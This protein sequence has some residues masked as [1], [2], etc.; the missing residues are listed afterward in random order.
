MFL[1]NKT[2]ASMRVFEVVVSMPLS[3]EGWR[4]FFFWGFFPKGDKN[5]KN[6]IT[7]F[8]R[9]TKTLNSLLHKKIQKKKRKKNSKKNTKKK[10]NRFSN[11]IK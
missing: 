5:D 11:D 9:L 2:R 7:L 4:S 8:Y 6:F 10:K 1:F 3:N